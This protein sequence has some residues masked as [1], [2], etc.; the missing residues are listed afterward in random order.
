MIEFQSG[1]F[2]RR[3]DNWCNT[4]N[5]KVPILCSWHNRRIWNDNLAIEK[6]FALCMVYCLGRALNWQSNKLGYYITLYS[7]IARSVVLRRRNQTIIDLF[8]NVFIHNAARSR[9]SLQMAKPCKERIIG[10][11]GR[12]QRYTIF[13]T[14]PCAEVC[15]DDCICLQ[16]CLLL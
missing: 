1:I 2:M 4:C 7:P 16:K 8:G 3:Q 10:S 11:W 13:T 9:L 12:G 14:T 15:K 5:G 6:V